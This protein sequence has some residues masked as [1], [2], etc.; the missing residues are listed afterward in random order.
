M[1]WIRKSCS[2]INDPTAGE[3]TR[4]CCPSDVNRTLQFVVTR[5]E[6]RPLFSPAARYLP[7]LLHLMPQGPPSVARRISRPPCRVPAKDLCIALHPR[8]E[9]GRRA[10]G[11]PAHPALCPVSDRMNV[12]VVKKFDLPRTA[13]R[14]HT[15]AGTTRSE[16]SFL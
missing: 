3:V 7:S 16:R 12:P 11:D 9:V 1:D 4:R 10:V 13:A 6:I 2:A 15:G 14:L 5:T 8:D